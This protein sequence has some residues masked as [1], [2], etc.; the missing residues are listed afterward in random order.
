VANNT[1][2]SD[3]R[4]KL[5]TL[6]VLDWA[7]KNTDSSVSVKADIEGNNFVYNF[8]SSHHEFGTYVTYY[9]TT[10]TYEVSADY[11]Y[12]AQTYED[13]ASYDVYEAGTFDSADDAIE[14]AVALLN[15]EEY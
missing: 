8:A 13:Q 14:H 1:L 11:L 5:L 15:R 6:S 4:A 2:V 12:S 10:D 7:D 9:G 3:I